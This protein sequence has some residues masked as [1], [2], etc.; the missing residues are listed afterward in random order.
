M[1]TPKRRVYRAYGVAGPPFC[2]GFT[3]RTDCVNR[4]A[5]LLRPGAVS[6]KTLGKVLL[7][8]RLTL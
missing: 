1:H 6:A 7:L 4:S 8:A 3:W 5:D 2:L